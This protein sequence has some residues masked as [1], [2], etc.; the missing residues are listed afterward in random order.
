MGQESGI[1]VSCGVGLRHGLDPVL[2]CRRPTALALIRPLAWELP[3]AVGVALRRK[4]K[5]R[6][7]VL[8]VGLLYRRE[9]R[10]AP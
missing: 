3:Y 10:K 8:N 9:S 7:N 4:K 1:A 2:L 5:N 6:E